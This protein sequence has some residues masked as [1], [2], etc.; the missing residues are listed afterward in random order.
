[1]ENPPLMKPA[2]RISLDQLE[3]LA[4]R[5]K[6][7]AVALC[8][9]RKAQAEKEISLKVPVNKVPADIPFEVAKAFSARETLVVRGC[10]CE[11]L[12]ID[13][14]C[15]CLTKYKLKQHKIR[16]VLTYSVVDRTAQVLKGGH[17]K[18]WK[19]YPDYIFS[20]SSKVTRSDEYA[21]THF[22]LHHGKQIMMDELE[23][24]R[25]WFSVKWPKNAK[26]KYFAV[27]LYGKLVDKGF[28]PRAKEPSHE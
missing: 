21:E 17:R 12:G 25:V 8:N 6:K 1:M 28:L 18:K 19:Y 11:F 3:Q 2:K 15:K 7:I 14:E 22:V 10:D 4:N 26:G 5:N 20:L 27:V 9:F 23:R 13:K 16:P 24:K